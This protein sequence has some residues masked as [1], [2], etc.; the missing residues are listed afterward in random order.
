M[1]EHDLF[2]TTKQKLDEIKAKRPYCKIDVDIWP[3]A[4]LSKNDIKSVWFIRSKK[5]KI[6]RK[7]RLILHF[8]PRFDELEPTDGEIFSRTPIMYKK[9]EH[10]TGPP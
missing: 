1:T 4:G 3:I 7:S 8:M 6:K 5:Y 2:I 10:Q 9:N